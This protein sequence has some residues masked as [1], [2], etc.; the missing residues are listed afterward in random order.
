MDKEVHMFPK[1]ITPI[2]HVISRLEF[3]LTYN[4]V[5]V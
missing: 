2:V 3:E 4:S 1:G 5:T